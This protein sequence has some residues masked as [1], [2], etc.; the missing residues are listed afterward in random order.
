T[1]PYVLPLAGSFST[2]TAPGITDALTSYSLNWLPFANGTVT[3]PVVAVFEIVGV[4][5]PASPSASPPQ[6]KKSAG[7]GTVPIGLS[8]VY[9]IELPSLET[10][11]ESRSARPVVPEVP[12]TITA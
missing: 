7:L 5:V 1:V 11:A 3:V 8:N 2:V 6:T 4:P 9:A 12:G 10:T